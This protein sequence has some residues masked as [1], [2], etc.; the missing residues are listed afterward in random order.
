MNLSYRKRMTRNFSIN[1]SYVLSRALAYN[2]KRGRFR[3]RPDR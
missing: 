2:G 3:Q 1:A